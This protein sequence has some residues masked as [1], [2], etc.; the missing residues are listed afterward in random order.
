VLA[1]RVDVVSLVGGDV[2][3]CVELC[4]YSDVIRGVKQKVSTARY[5]HWR[6]NDFASQT[7]PL[8]RTNADKTRTFL[9]AG[10]AAEAGVAIAR[11]ERDAAERSGVSGWTDAQVGVIPVLTRGVQ[12]AGVALALVDIREAISSGISWWADAL[13]V[14]TGQIRAG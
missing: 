1:Q 5:D 3:E 13:E 4:W 6:Y 2:A 10:P 8:W 11:S 7:G 14:I 9:S 12:R